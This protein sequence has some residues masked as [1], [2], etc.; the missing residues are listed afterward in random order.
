MELLNSNDSTL[1]LSLEHPIFTDWLIN[2]PDFQAYWRGTVTKGN[3]VYVVIARILPF[4]FIPNHLS[5]IGPPDNTFLLKIL[6]TPGEDRNAND[7]QLLLKFIRHHKILSSVRENRL[8]DICKSLKA[9]YCPPGTSV[10]TQGDPGDAFYIVLS[11]ELD[12]DIDGTVVNTLGSGKSFGEKALENDAPRGASVISK[13]PCALM[14]LLAFDYKHMAASAQARQNEEITMFLHESCTVMNYLSHAKIAH[15]VRLASR[16]RFKQ[17]DT[18]LVQD[19][20]PAGL[21]VIESGTVSITR[22]IEIK[23]EDDDS[24]YL[25]SVL[26]L[27]SSDSFQPLLETEG[28]VCPK[29][30]NEDSKCFRN[31]LHRVVPIAELNKGQVLGDDI[32]RKKKRNTYGKICL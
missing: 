21:L 4:I 24:N 1:D 30:L 18:I 25:P 11:G 15:I 5:T 10:V 22:N 26:S 29:K 16:Q 17:G 32:C 9:M 13:T 23:H 12:V 28:H 27:T 8:L 2:R 7:L 19:E 31:V 3:D 20:V 14:M 6:E